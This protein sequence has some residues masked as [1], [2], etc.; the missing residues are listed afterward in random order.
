M[1]G[2]GRRRAWEERMREGGAEGLEGEGE[3]RKERGKRGRGGEGRGGEGKR[4][5]RRVE[6]SGRR[7][8]RKE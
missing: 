7:K 3:E 1:E 2:G 5:R 8:G 6:D 4:R